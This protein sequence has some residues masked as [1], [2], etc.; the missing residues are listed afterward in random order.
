MEQNVVKTQRPRVKTLR[1][2]EPRIA[3]ESVLGLHPAHQGWFDIASPHFYF[4]DAEAYR[5]M[6]EGVSLRGPKN[7]AAT[8]TASSTGG[9]GNAGFYQYQ[10]R[11]GYD[12]CHYTKW[13]PKVA[14]TPDQ[15]QWLRFDFESEIGTIHCRSEMEASL[16]HIILGDRSFLFLK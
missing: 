8:V 4:H 16:R 15:P 6:R 1:A 13:I 5:M 10:P 9:W 14:P 7:F 2:A 3:L 11:D 12:G